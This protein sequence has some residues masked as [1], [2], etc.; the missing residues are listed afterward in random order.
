MTPTAFDEENTVL[1]APPQLSREYNIQPLSCHIGK[2]EDGTPVIISCW[3]PSQEE[4]EEIKR[5]GRV[6]VIVL[7]NVMVPL[8]ITG[9]YPFNLENHPRK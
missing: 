1:D 2:Q 9:Y 3:K 7:G 4:L 5:T 6:W 8:D